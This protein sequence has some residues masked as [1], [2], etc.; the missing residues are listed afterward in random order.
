MPIDRTRPGGECN[1]VEKR[2]SMMLQEPQDM[3]LQDAVL[4]I[5][6]EAVV[7]NWRTLCGLGAGVATA[8]VVKADAYG[9]GAV[10][11]APALARA[12]CRCFFV[13][14]LSEAVA[15]RACLRPL[16][17]DDRIE[18]CV[19]NGVRAPMIEAF[20]E[21]RLIPVLNDPAQVSEWL[22][23]C[24]ARHGPSPAILHLD[25][26]MNRLGLVAGDFEKLVETQAV[27][28]FP[29]RALMTHLA[30][31]DE[32]DHPMNGRQC[33]A[34]RAQAK[35]LPGVGVSIA[36][37][38]GILLGKAYHGDL[39]RPGA[40]LYGLDPRTPIGGFAPLGLAQPVTLQARILQLHTVASGQTVGYS[41][42]YRAARASVIAT[43]ALGYADGYPR[44]AFGKGVFMVR[45]VA[46]PMVGRISMDLI[47][48]DVTGAPGVCAA[49]WVEVIGP[50]HT[51][52]Q[53]AEESGTIGREIATHLGARYHRCYLGAGRAA[54]T[55]HAAR[56]DGEG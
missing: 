50:R 32:P 53:I 4:T 22:A 28:G 23:A 6:L 39:L 21:Y 29:W 3:A 31:S 34:L 49:D 35:N 43:I 27:T 46:V 33:A 47:T 51:I 52:D 8:A 20:F 24:Q 42:G 40:M 14:C 17:P 37:S 25:T 13:S 18:V 36:A 5:D 26:G 1:L 44:V 55:G 56:Q 2:E 15:L 9:L 30:C 7:A 10:Q 12:G 16:D 11:V 19:L 45:G 54:R 41:E 48:L 38:G